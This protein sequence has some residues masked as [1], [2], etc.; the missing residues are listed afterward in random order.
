MGF[1]PA[2]L[3]RILDE[4]GVAFVVIG[5]A[6]A[7]LRGSPTVTNDIDVTPERDIDNAERLFEALAS[8]NARRPVA[9]LPPVDWPAVDERDFLG[10]GAVSYAT[11][12]GPIDIVPYPKALGGYEDLVPR[13]E[14]FDIG[15]RRVLV[16]ALDD[17]I[18]SKEQLGRP[19]DRSQLP[20]LYATR[21]VQRRLEKE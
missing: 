10:W 15:G 17:V 7:I 18:E 19:K 11:D 9:G 20:A 2:A 1:D 21:D 13:A 8:T 4:H 14:L 3:L 5:H 12:H 6:A 16:A